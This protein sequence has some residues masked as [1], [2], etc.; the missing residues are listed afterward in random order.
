MRER[1]IP[2]I[3]TNTTTKAMTDHEDESRGILVFE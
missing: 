2:R 1:M 3:S